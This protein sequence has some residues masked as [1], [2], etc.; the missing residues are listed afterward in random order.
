MPNSKWIITLGLLLFG[1][2][3]GPGF[4]GPDKI[5]SLGFWEAR[6]VSAP[7]ERDLVFV[8]RVKK[9]YP[10]AVR[11]SPKRWAIVTDIDKVLSGK[12]SGATFTFT[13]HSPEKA[14][15]QVGRIYTIKAKWTAAGYV[16]DE[17]Q[18]IKPAEAR[19]SA[20]H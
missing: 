20:R 8:G 3:E 14:G 17:T 4:N 10:L 16:V 6:I 5:A 19:R 13:V 18:W 12:F 11:N 15:L 9:I 7:E 1:V 2:N